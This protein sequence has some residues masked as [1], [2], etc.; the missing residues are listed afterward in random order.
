MQVDVPATEPDVYS[1]LEGLVDIHL[2]VVPYGYGWVFHHGGYYSVGVGSFC[3]KVRDP[4]SALHR[5]ARKTRLS[6]AGVVP[7]GHFVPCGGV[8]GVVCADR[9]LLAGDAAGFADPFFGEGM[10]YAIRSGQLAAETARAARQ[11]SDFS[12][13]SLARYGRLC[14]EEFGS[15]MRSAL[16]LT[17]LMHGSP[18]SFLAALCSDRSVLRKC[19]HVLPAKLSYGQY[20]LWLIAR[21]PLTLVRSAAA[22]AQLPRAAQLS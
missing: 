6:L 3:C 13:R 4:V 15:D 17:R 8:P 7:R 18:R 21:A 5:F 22:G 9:V 19:L 10:A 12:L 16:V 14:W 1:D 2:G 20:L 11:K